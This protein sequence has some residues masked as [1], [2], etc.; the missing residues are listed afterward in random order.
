MAQHSA[1]VHQKLLIVD[2]L[3]GVDQPAEFKEEYANR[4]KE[5]GVTATHVTIPG[6]ERFDAAY[7]IGELAEWFH[8]MRKLEPKG[9]KLATTVRDIRLAKR[10]GTVA[11]VLG[12]QAAAFLGDNLNMLEL[13]K[14]LGMRTMQ[15]TYQ[16]RNQLG[17][18]CAEKTDSGLS[19]LGVEWVEKM[20][21][22][23]MLISLSHVG[24]RTSMDVMDISKDPVVFDHSN[25]R[26]LC[27]HIRNIRDDQIE[28][29]ADKGGVIGACAAAMFLRKDKRPDELKVNDFIDHID[30]LVK[31]V[32]ID[33]VGIGLDLSETHYSTPEQL[34]ER[35]RKF[36]G[37]TSEKIREVEDEFLKS[38]RNRLNHYEFQI[39]WLKSISRIQ[40][41]TDALLSR[42]Y[43][44]QDAAKIMGENFLKVFERVWGE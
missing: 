20:N 42:G 14:E 16:R 30:Y 32:G 19:L 2:G 25:P 24:Y 37:L 21:E 11:A 13:L 31:L 1:G 17:D 18:G 33:H 44:D 38:G 40:I 7:A 10:N 36:P 26:T 41:I 35:R 15:P 39:P 12:S 28:L 5:G 27:D 34:L 23:G 22:L 43:S 4:L 3:C 9:I 29:C 6:V 8:E